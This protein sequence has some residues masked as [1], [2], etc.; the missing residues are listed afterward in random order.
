MTWQLSFLPWSKSWSV[1][2]CYR[3]EER[4]GDTDGRG[5]RREKENNERER[6]RVK[7]GIAKGG[8]R[9]KQKAIAYE[10]QLAPLMARETKQRS[11][12][13][14]SN[15]IKAHGVRV[16]RSRGQ[17]DEEHE[18]EE[19]EERPRGGG[20]DEREEIKSP[21]REQWRHRG[22]CCRCCLL[23][24]DDAVFTLPLPTL[25]LFPRGFLF[26]VAFTP[27]F[28]RL[29]FFPAVPFLHRYIWL[30]RGNRCFRV[31]RPASR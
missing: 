9:R 13:P 6:E 19:G 2:G 11:E 27:S 24:S 18:A 17:E 31:A 8:K 22:S 20:K 14:S 4:E 5:L 7:E 30:P 16:S 21:E 12:A 25:S 23:L 26:R 29:L 10:R 15:T 1:A 3:I 28:F